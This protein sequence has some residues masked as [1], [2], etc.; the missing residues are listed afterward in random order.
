MLLLGMSEA[1]IASIANY[2]ATTIGKIVKEVSQCI[3]ENMEGYF[4]NV[5]E[6]P[7]EWLEIA[8]GFEQK[9]GLPN[10]IGAIGLV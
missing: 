1:G 6:S 8:A 10:C 9:T 3:I 5:P 4:L 7:E 2:G